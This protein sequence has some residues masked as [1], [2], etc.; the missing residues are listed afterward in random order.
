MTKEGNNNHGTF[1]FLV[2]EVKFA[3]KE[4]YTGNSNEGPSG[5]ATISM[6]LTAGQ[7][8]RIENSASTVLYGTDVSGA[9]RSWFTGHLLY[10]L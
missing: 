8:V 6:E 1:W 9:M 4:E 7:I 10:A 3:L 5:S 2:D